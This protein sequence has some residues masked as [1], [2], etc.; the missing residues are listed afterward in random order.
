MWSTINFTDRTLTIGTIRKG[1][2][3][4]VGCYMRHGHNV[5]L[6]NNQSI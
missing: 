1:K 4:D 5:Y 3:A 6:M 2:Q